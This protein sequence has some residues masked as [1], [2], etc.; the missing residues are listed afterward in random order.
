MEYSC[1]MKEQAPQPTLTIRTRTAVQDLPQ[2]MGESYGA[3]TQYLAVLG[4][5]P[6]GPPFTAY[7]NMDMQDLD[8]E[9]GFAVA[10]KL[11]GSEDIQAGEMLMGKMASCVFTGP[12]IEMAPAYEALAAWVE[13]NGYEPTGIAYEFYLNDP[14]EVP[15]E[16]LM[17][18]IVFPLK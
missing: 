4:E 9:I 10:K 14:G 17:T 2:V 6:A 13:K 11:A 16:E 5:Q 8:V 15:P 1:E 18:Q 3:I 7:Y 12:Y